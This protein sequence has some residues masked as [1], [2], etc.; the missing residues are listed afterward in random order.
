MPTCYNINT[1]EGKL[2]IKAL[3]ATVAAAAWVESPK[4]TEEQEVL[5]GPGVS[6]CLRFRGTVTPYIG[7]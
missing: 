2:L 4:G 3:G 1:R 6:A 7:C 5:L